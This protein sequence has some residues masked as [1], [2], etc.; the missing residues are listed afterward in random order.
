MAA[1]MV[2]TIA[3]L[4]Y[5]TNRSTIVVKFVNT[6]NAICNTYPNKTTLLIT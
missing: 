3:S 2:P 4:A 5:G 6:G 1:N